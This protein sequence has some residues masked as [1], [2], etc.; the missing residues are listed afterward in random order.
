[1]NFLRTDD[2]LPCRQP[3]VDALLDVLQRDDGLGALVL[4]ETGMGKTCLLRAL[5]RAIP[6][7]RPRHVVRAA[8]ALHSVPYGALGDFFAGVPARDFTSPIPLLRT[9]RQR[10][11]RPDGG[12]A[13]AVLVD[14]AQFL[15][16]ESTHVLTQLVVMGVVRLIAFADHSLT[17][18]SG[19]HGFAG[20]G[21]LDRVHLEPLT[22]ATLRAVAEHAL[23]PAPAGTEPLGTGPLG[24][25]A[26]L[27]LRESTGGNPML[28][29]AVLGHLAPDGAQSGEGD[30][31]HVDP[32]RPRPAGALT[33]LVASILAPMPDAQRTA[34][35]LLA[36]G[37]AVPA[38]DVE[39]LTGSEAVRT[40]ID[41]RF[42]AAHPA[43]ARYLTLRHG[44]YGEVI[45]AVLPLGRKALLRARLCGPAFDVPP[46]GCH[47]LRHLEW[48]LDTGAPVEAAMLLDAARVATGLGRL[49]ASEQFL[50][51]VPAGSG[52]GIAVERARL[53]SARGRPAEAVRLLA[54]RDAGAGIRVQDGSDDAAADVAPVRAVVVAQ[55]TAMRLAGAPASEVVALLESVRTS[56]V[57]PG[58][59]DAGTTVGADLLR[60]QLLLDQG[61]PAA[62]DLLLAEDRFLAADPEPFGDLRAVALALRGGA[63]GLR[64]RAVEAA[65]CTQAAFD[66]VIADPYRFA[67]VAEDVLTQHVLVLAQAGAADHALAALGQAETATLPFGPLEALRGIVL[68]RRGDFRTGMQALVP[69]LA[70]LRRVDRQL[71]LPYAVGVAAWGAAVLGETEQATALIEELRALPP[72]GRLDL[73][74][75]GRAFAAAAGSLESRGPQRPTRFAA[76]VDEV[77][78]PDLRACEKDILVL[79][80]LLGVAGATERLALVAADLQ[81]DEALIL[82][83]VARAAG[84]RDGAALGEVADRAAAVGLPLIALEAAARAR[85]VQAES[86]THADIRT[87]ARRLGR[88]GAPFTGTS[89]EVPGGARRLTDLTRSEDVVARLV[90]GGESNRDIAAAL[91]VS[92]RTVEGH[93]HRIY[94]KLGISGRA[95][96]VREL[97]GL[98]VQPL[99]TTT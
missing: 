72:R 64:G 15:D 11:H 69:A 17:P 61:K 93:L 20:E 4:G 48:A 77:R 83:G 94:V 37:G 74:I 63:L 45:R 99:Q 46:Y 22:D 80:V 44:L 30:G 10:L 8:R 79:A 95:D 32:V 97:Q 60:A 53:L 78:P 65:R 81:G 71:L 40:L 58:T 31:W 86:G 56:H 6:A 76:L 98:G 87:A 24:H 67:H 47:R 59:A 13:C 75:M 55:G 18:S 1:M 35:D 34:M 42:V 38:A 90:A 89:F 91:C 21:Y 9:A 57:E 43:D 7:A 39:R 70:R 54:D 3:V 85:D 52:P 16:E 5:E 2:L 14:D 19:L 50:H 96:L 73:G 66:A 33:D 29:K 51:A 26:L 68:L 88:H 25:R 84:A 49:A 62:V 36:L 12:G 27:G 41:Q 28:L 92:V 82:A 23:R